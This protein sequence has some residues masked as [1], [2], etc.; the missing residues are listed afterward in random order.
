MK[1]FSTEDTIWIAPDNWVVRDIIPTNHIDDL[2]FLNIEPFSIPGLKTEI[3][4]EIVSVNEVHNIPNAITLSQN[5]P[6]PFNPTT[7]IHYAIKERASVEIVLYDILGR[8]VEVLVNEE[9]DAGYYKIDFNASR[10]ASGIYFY[11]LQAGSF[12]ETKKMVLLK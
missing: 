9:Q 5:Y 3:I 8:E 2:Q 12:V 4:D 7:T 10:L 6:N 11:R 1:L